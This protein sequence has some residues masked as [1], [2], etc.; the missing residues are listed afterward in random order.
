VN[1]SPVQLVHLTFHRV[2]VETDSEHLAVATSESVDAHGMF[3]GVIVRTGATKK[4]IDKED[5]RG[6][7]YFLTLRL[8]ID[9]E[10]DPSNSAQKFSPYKVDVEAGGV[11]IV[12]NGADALGDLEDLVTVNGLALVWG[13]IREQVATL[14]S[15][16]PAGTA[17]LP[18]VNFLDM[19]KGAEGSDAPVSRQ[20]SSSDKVAKTTPKRTRARKS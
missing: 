3:D 5:H 2:S 20:E 15:R 6:I 14:T 1:I 12:A 16:M 4:R 19:R 13:A 10:A 9:N 8:L 11:V 18:S 7:P 17:L